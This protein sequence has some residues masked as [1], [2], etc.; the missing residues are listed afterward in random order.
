MGTSSISD[1]KVIG[2]VVPYPREELSF[3]IERG[4]MESRLGSNFS[5]IF[6]YWIH[7]R[8]FA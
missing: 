7:A 6:S 4:T 5:L 1:Y 8:E 3:M 2:W